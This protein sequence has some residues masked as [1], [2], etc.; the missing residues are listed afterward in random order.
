MIAAAWRDLLVERAE[1]YPVFK[2]RDLQPEA[3]HPRRLIAAWRARGDVASL[4]HG[5]H[6]VAEDG[7]AVV[8]D[9]DLAAFLVAATRFGNQLPALCT[10]SAARIHGVGGLDP[11]LGTVTVPMPTRPVSLADARGTITFCTRAERVPGVR[12]VDPEGDV[13]DIVGAGAIAREVVRLRGLPVTVTT[14]EQTALDLIHD[15]RTLDGAAQLD[16]CLLHL[17]SRSEQERLDSIAY[18]QRRRRA[19]ATYRERVSL[20]QAWR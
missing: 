11:A 2:A 12:N 15:P 3:T 17:A 13:P 10:I 18:D 8:G 9:I 5:Y 6:V 4:A 7:S 16:A 20:L 14:R 19:R 1:G